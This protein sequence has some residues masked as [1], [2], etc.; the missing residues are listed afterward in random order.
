MPQ[1]KYNHHGSISNYKCLIHFTTVSLNK[2]WFY[3]VPIKKSQCRQTLLLLG[4]PIHKHLLFSFYST[5]QQ[6]IVE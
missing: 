2:L 5:I 6:S 4:N 1:V 3:C